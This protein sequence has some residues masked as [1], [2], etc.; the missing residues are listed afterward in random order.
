[1]SERIRAQPGPWFREHWRQVRA[2]LRGSSRRPSRSLLNPLQRTVHVHRPQH[3]PFASTEAR[4]ISQALKRCSASFRST[5][6]LQWKERPGHPGRARRFLVKWTIVQHTR[7]LTLDIILNSSPK[8]TELF[9]AMQERHPFPSSVSI[10]HPAPPK[11]KKK[12]P[13]RSN[14]LLLGYPFKSSVLS[15][16]ISFLKKSVFNLRK[17]QGPSICNVKLGWLLELRMA[18]FTAERPSTWDF[19]GNFLH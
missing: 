7:R 15:Q 16:V 12:N 2:G 11:K 19:S 4:C 1:M 18:L 17:S 8:E 5:A 13:E 9:V 3:P 14:F 10:H 6:R